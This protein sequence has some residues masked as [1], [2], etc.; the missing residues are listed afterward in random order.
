MELIRFYCNPITKPSV[1]LVDTEAHHLL[2]VRRLK[3]GDKVELFDGQGTLATAAITETKH[4]IVTL[5]IENLKKTKKT[6]PQIIIAVS[7]PKGERF[8]LTITKCTELGI[9]RITPIIFERTVKQ[10]KNP[11]AVSRWQKLTIAAAKQSRNLFLPKIDEP[12]NLSDAIEMLKKN[13][14]NAKLLLGSP[15]S[16]AP[17]LIN[18]SF[19]DTDIIAVIGPEGGLTENELTL[20]KN[21]KAESVRLTDT[22]LRVETAAIAFAAILAAKRI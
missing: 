20:L 8:D 1:E 13:H 2:N 19:G 21:Q 10:S 12:I 18:Q 6:Y 16:K 5:E 17:S 9:D 7:I 14:P 3:T 4:K 22:I 15:D 11:K